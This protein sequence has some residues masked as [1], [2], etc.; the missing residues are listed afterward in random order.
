[1]GFIFLEKSLM[2]VTLCQ[3]YSNVYVLV[4]RYPQQ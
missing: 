3:Y 4:N 2:K 1:M